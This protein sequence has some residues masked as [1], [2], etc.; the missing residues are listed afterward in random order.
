MKAFPNY[1]ILTSREH[2]F[3]K[4]LSSMRMIVERAFGHL[5]ERWRILLKE[6]YCISIERIIKIIHACCILHNICIDMGDL[7][8][9]ENIDREMDDNIDNDEHEAENEERE[10]IA[11]AQKREYLAN[12]IN[13]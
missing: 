7:L 4:I 6:I 9:S 5:K 11:G 12:L 8:F 3:N 1:Y 13:L 10:E 2:H